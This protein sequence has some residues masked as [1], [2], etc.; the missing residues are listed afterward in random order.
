MK[1]HSRQKVSGAK[2]RSMF[3]GRVQFSLARVSGGEAWV[4]EMGRCQVTKGP[5]GQA[6]RVRL[7]LQSPPLSP[8]LIKLTPNTAGTEEI[9]LP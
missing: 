1:E 3:R 8:D 2:A 5:G 6:E 4:G 7:I 9:S